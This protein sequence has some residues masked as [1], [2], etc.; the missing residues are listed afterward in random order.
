MFQGIEH[1]AIATP[2]P[3]TLAAWYAQ[4][5]DFKIAHRYASNVFI[6]AP[7]GS[8]IELIPSV[9]ER[10]HAEMRSPGIRHLAI[11]VEDIDAGVKELESRGIEITNRVEA[12]GNR[13]AFFL[14]P[15][16]N[17]LHLIWRDKKI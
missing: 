11:S 6:Q 2:D 14:D 13:L 1:T 12:E 8:M 16:G 10:P 17:I 4:K 9:G 7:D 15:E 3:E 5:L